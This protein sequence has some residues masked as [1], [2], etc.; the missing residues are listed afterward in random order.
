MPLTLTTRL[1]LW[2]GLI[3]TLVVSFLAYL[4]F[5]EVKPNVRQVTENILSETAQLLANLAAQDQT[6][7]PD[8]NTRQPFV[9]FQQLYEERAKEHQLNFYITNTK[10]IVIFD[11]NHQFVGQDFSQW[12]DVYLTLRHQYGARSTLSNVNDPDSSVMYVAAPIYRNS[13]MVGVLTVY[14]SNLTIL[15]LIEAGQMRIAYWGLGLVIVIIIIALLSAHWVKKVLFQLTDYAYQIARGSMSPQPVMQTPELNVLANALSHMRQELDGKTTIE[16]YVYALTHELKSPITAI[17]AAVE[18]LQEADSDTHQA[19]FLELITTQ[20]VRMQTLVERLLLLA[21]IESQVSVV[22][23]RIMSLSLIE[24]VCHNL[25]ASFLQ[26]KI[27]CDYEHIENRVI[28]GDAFLLKL[29]LI[30]VLEN[31]LD[32]SADQQKIVITGAV[33]SSY[34]QFTIRDFG[35]GIPEFAYSQL[36]N[37]FFSLPRRHKQKSSGLGLALVQEIAR[38]HS[39]YIHIHNHPQGGVIVSFAI[40]LYPSKS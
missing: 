18:I 29:A 39:G 38:L 24:E 33:E 13:V 36:F 3:L 7:F 28:H 16:R 26:R 30:N 31:A 9:S 27:Q 23:E 1:L 19:H 40:S 20:T 22:Y 21:K 14:K 17:N 2:H 5:N 25:Q 12:R 34:Y 6:L 11:S 37:R 32:F 4:F 35:S 10:G 15:P 8:S